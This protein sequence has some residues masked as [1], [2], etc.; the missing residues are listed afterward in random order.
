MFK[1]RISQ[2]RCVYG[3]GMEEGRC[4]GGLS[5]VFNFV[6]L[7]SDDQVVNDLFLFFA[8][9]S[10]TVMV[11]IDFCLQCFKYLFSDRSCDMIESKPVVGT[12]ICM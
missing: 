8:L 2:A 10:E 3:E 5:P 4:R 11:F 12:V 6:F 1:S 7:C 9:L